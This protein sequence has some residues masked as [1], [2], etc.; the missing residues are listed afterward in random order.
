MKYN[1]EFASIIREIGFDKFYCM[2]WSPMQLDLYKDIMKTK[3]PLSIDAT[4]SVVRKLKRPNNQSS[5]IF[6]YQAVVPTAEGIFPVFQTLSEKYDAN[7]ISY[8]I[9]EW[10]RSGAPVPHETVTDFSFALLNGISLAFNECNLKTYVN[11][12][13][14]HLSGKNIQTTIRCYI[15]VDIAH[16][17]KLITKWK[18]FQ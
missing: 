4:G 17:I 6:L 12:C 11:Y 7:T 13:L 2:Y 10:L 16:T 9:K 18:C 3:V 8:F 5:A 15:R 14:C 1:V